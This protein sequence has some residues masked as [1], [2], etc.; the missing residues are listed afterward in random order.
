MRWLL[1]LL[2]LTVPAQA[3]DAGNADSPR[4]PTPLQVAERF[5]A[6]A[7]SGEWTRLRPPMAPALLSSI[8]KALRHAGEDVAIPWSS[9]SGRPSTCDASFVNGIE[10]APIVLV[11]VTYWLPDGSQRVDQVQM[12]RTPDSWVVDNVLYEGGGNLR[13]RLAEL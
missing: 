3:W 2:L 13:F 8:V 10:N 7:I 1:P 4:T 9:L 12:D 6:A 5:C 11:A